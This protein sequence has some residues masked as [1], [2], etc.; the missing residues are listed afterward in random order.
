MAKL[1][2][3]Q[4]FMQHQ[5]DYHGFFD[6]FDWYVTAHRW[7]ALID[8]TATVAHVGLAAG[9]AG[10][11]V[12]L[13]TGAVDNQDVA[14]YGTNEVLLFADDKP[15]YFEGSALFNE[16]AANIANF[17]IG[18]RNA[19]AVNL[20]GDNGTG[21]AGL[22]FS[23][24]MIYKVDGGT[25]FKCAC[26]VGAFDTL[27]QNTETNVSITAAATCNSRFRIQGKAENATQYTITYWMDAANDGNWQQLQDTN[28]N[29]IIHTLTYTGA[30][31]MAPFAYA[32]AGDGTSSIVVDVDYIGVA[33]RR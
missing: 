19:V 1:V 5:R 26:C 3:I 30:T 20:L 17:A 10:G 18:F 24:A 2:D 15:I 14:V 28:G 9:G 6:D 22:T 4:S 12:R 16:P 32:K 27:G 11:K 25:K 21:L 13:T 8:G 23:G 29:P 31:E 33:Q 7:T